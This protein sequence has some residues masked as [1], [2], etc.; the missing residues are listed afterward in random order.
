LFIVHFYF[1]PFTHFPNYLK[2]NLN[3]EVCFNIIHLNFYNP[4]LKIVI[5]LENLKSKKNHILNIGSSNPKKIIDLVKLLSSKY[6]NIPRR[7]GEPQITFANI[8]KA[9]KILN[10]KPR[11][12][13]KDGIKELLDNINYWKEAPLWD[14][15][16]IKKATKVWF[17]YL[18]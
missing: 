9:K 8:L 11:I 18:R 12:S 15:E 13:F 5:N 10:W 3:F 1:T 7:P 17:Q 16:K 4:L 14:R 6:T 2:N